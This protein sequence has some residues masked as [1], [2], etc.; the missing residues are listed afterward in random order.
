[1]VQGIFWNCL[2]EIRKNE[3]SISAIFRTVALMIEQDITDRKLHRKVD[4]LKQILTSKIQTQ[5]GIMTL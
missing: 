1:M 3:A 4:S 2:W 5:G